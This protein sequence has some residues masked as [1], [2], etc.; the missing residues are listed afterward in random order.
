MYVCMYAHIHRLVHTYMHRYMYKYV[1]VRWFSHLRL[2]LSLRFSAQTY[3]GFGLQDGS[4]RGSGNDVVDRL[5]SMQ[6]LLGV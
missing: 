1:F 4:G 5:A 6:W 2:S 3:D